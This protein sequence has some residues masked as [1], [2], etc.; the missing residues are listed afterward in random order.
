MRVRRVTQKDTQKGP[1]GQV[2]LEFGD[3]KKEIPRGPSHQKA[4]SLKS[5][6]GPLVRRVTQKHKKKGP[7]GQVLLKF[8]DLKK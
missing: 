4:K 7:L 5:P 2:L 1:L 3:M 6:R 8:G